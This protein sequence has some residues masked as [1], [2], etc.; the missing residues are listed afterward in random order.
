[1]M[2]LVSKNSSAIVAAF[3]DISEK[4]CVLEFLKIENSICNRTF[5][6]PENSR[7][8]IIPMPKNEVYTNLLSRHASL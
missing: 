1:M 3:F 7:R 4:K 2:V 5:N 6:S 8:I